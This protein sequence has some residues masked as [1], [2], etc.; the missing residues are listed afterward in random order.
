MQ[1]L[2]SKAYLEQ[3]LSVP[4]AGGE[5]ILAFY[6]HRVGAICKDVSVLL[7][8]LDDHLCH[9]GDGVFESIAIRSGRLLQLDAHIKRMQSSAAGIK[10]T[11]PCAWDDIRNIILSVAATAGCEHGAIRI[12]LGRGPGGFDISPAE[13]PVASLYVVAIK[14]NI[15]TDAWYAKG[16]TACRSSIPAKQGYLAKLKN[17]NYLPNVL[18]AEEAAERK[19]DV[20]FSFDSQGYLAEAAIAN[21]AI[22]RKDDVFASPFIEH[23]LPGTTL[24]AAM[25]EAKAFMKAEY[26]NISEQDIFEAKEVLLFGST[27][28]C[29]GITHYEGRP[30]GEA[31]PGPV[32]KELKQRLAERLVAEGVPFLS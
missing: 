21:V 3:M 4:R 14:G 12:L 23:I 16:L 27:P 15:P 31:K 25:D 13:C 20:G 17:T 19:V 30:I 7:I 28:L 1:V 8:P 32:A 29:V 2:D 22:V 24:L 18:M 26:C 9:R 11:P 6:D 5:K 10:I